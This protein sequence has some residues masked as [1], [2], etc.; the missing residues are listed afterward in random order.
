MATQNT[1]VPYE[2]NPFNIGL[3]G[4][5]LLFSNARSV[6]IYAIIISAVSFVV[7]L[8]SN[9]IDTVNRLNTDSTLQPDG[10]MLHEGAPAATFPPS[11]TLLV[12]F[13]VVIA[14]I[15]FV[16]IVVVTWLAG[17]LEYT[18]A[19]LALGK[20]TTFSQAFSE[21]TKQLA[22]YL[23]LNILIGIKTFL[24]SLLLIVPGFIMSVRY[25]LATTAFFAEGKHGE[26]AIKRSLELTKG[27]WFTTFGA[28]S[29]WNFIT[30][31]QITALLQPGTNAIL[32]RQLRSVTD[33]GEQKPDAHWLS[34]LALVVPI[35]IVVLFISFFLL[36]FLLLN[37]A[38]K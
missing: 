16:L 15:L 18:A 36:L 3:N 22:A 6:A 21:V 12:I 35:V 24:W 8:I 7:N 32:F 34:W 33:A 25:S 14:S 31:S 37:L 38:T 1:K 11:F 5:R 29:L 9:I 4:L 2:N 13:A 28:R 26:E 30:F 23:W 20:K 19:Q 17:V 27:A 10:F